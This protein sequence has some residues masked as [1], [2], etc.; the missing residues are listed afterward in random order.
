MSTPQVVTYLRSLEAVRDRSKQVYKLGVDGKLDHWTFDE[1]KLADIADYCSK[2]ITV[3][4]IWFGVDHMLTKYL[5]R[6]FGTDYA[7][8]PRKLPRPQSL[9]NTS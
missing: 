4:L 7:S 8:I 6:D 9:P 2:I 3:S 5:Q 1:A